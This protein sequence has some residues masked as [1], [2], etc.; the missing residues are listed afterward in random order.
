MTRRWND[1]KSGL[2]QWIEDDFRSIRPKARAMELLEKVEGLFDGSPDDGTSLETWHEWLRVTGSTWYLQSLSDPELLNRWS[3]AAFRAIRRANFTLRDLF[4][5][6]CAEHPL[7]TF[8]QDMSGSATAHWTYAQVERLVREIATAFHVSVDNE[9]RVALLVEN[10]V[11]GACCDLAC[12]FFDILDTPLNVHF[13][14]SVLA[15]IFDITGVNVAVTDTQE[16]YEKLL[17]VARKTRAPFEIFV[18]DGAV[19]LEDGKGRFLKSHCKRF[20]NDEIDRVLAARRRMPLDEVATVMFTSGSTGKP[21]GVS[22]S[23]YNL[24]SK[25]FA[26]AAALPKVGDDEVMLCYLP[27]FH[28]FGRYLEML[29]TIYWGGTYVLHGQSLG[30]HAAVALSLGESHGVYFHPPPVEAARSGLLQADEARRP[31]G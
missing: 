25:R 27:L 22:F 21:K 11:E 26:R 24:V 28:T 23:M 6:R 29:G 16:R 14:A 8:F 17:Q 30:R 31:G 19:Q 12:L 13:D 1:L 15:E 3:E 7:K 20:G 2:E 9:P 18:L 5:M 4:T 10:S